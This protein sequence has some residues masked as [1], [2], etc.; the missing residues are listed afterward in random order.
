MAPHQA[1]HRYYIALSSVA[2]A[3]VGSY[4]LP[5][6]TAHFLD[7]IL[8]GNCLLFC[9]FGNSLKKP[10]YSGSSFVTVQHN[11]D[12]ISAV[13]VLLVFSISAMATNFT[14]SVLFSTVGK[15]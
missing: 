1:R 4:M 12:C 11:R 3:A 8:P 5:T 13:Q 14:I 10:I 2:F 9:D 15:S 7:E 6:N